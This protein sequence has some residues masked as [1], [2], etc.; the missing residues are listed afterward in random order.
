MGILMHLSCQTPTCTA[1]L[2]PHIIMHG[3]FLPRPTPRCLT[4][5]EIFQALRSFSLYMQVCHPPFP[6]SSHTFC[7]T[8]ASLYI[9]LISE[10]CATVHSAISPRP[11]LYLLRSR[12]HFTKL[13]SQTHLLSRSLLLPSSSSLEPASLVPSL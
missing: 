9:H 13:P 6:A 5:P 11:P 8:N 1:S 2:F 7:I 12:H 10:F 4:H 3:S